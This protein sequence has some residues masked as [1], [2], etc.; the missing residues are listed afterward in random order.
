MLLGLWEHQSQFLKLGEVHPE[1]QRITMDHHI[2]TTRGHVLVSFS[3]GY[4]TGSGYS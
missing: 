4:H 1:V 2:R 3:H